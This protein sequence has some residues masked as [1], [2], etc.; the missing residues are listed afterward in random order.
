M[1]PDARTDR[2]ALRQL[3]GCPTAI[4]SAV[5]RIAPQPTRRLAVLISEFSRLRI[6]W[7]YLEDGKLMRRGN[8]VMRRVKLPE[9]P[10]GF[11]AILPEARSKVDA[12]RVE[13]L[14]GIP[15]PPEKQT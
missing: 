15:A 2:R 6:L 1:P 8:Q 4:E 10:E 9:L 13:L 12:R 11:R 5:N 7:D 14:D 3:R